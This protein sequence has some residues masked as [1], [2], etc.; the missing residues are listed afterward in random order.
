[1]TDDRDAPSRPPEGGTP[2]QT[3][4][5]ACE[6]SLK[7]FIARLCRNDADA[8]DIAH[9]ALVN[10][11][12]VEADQ[13]IERP[14]AYLFRAARNLAL[15][16]QAKRSRE[17]IAYVDDAIVSAAASHEPSAEDQVI[18]RERYALFCAAV[19][20]LPPSCRRVFVMR[21]VY[22]CSHKE[23][24][25]RLGISTSTV[26]KHLSTGL[27]RC[28]AALSALEQGR[29]SDGDLGRAIGPRNGGV[30]RKP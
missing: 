22:G 8:D 24:A 28:R 20:T 6:R 19:A 16:R 5:F 26:E 12:R 13:V 4:F 11:L 17:V 21:K 2:V 3:A 14:E 27:A 30:T 15:K 18:D 9:D 1:M 29:R 23:I 7:R 25:E 10:A